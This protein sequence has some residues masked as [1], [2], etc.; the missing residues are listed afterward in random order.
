[1]KRRLFASLAAAA[2]IAAVCAPS[3]SIA[4]GRLTPEFEESAFAS[5]FDVYSETAGGTP[6]FTTDGFLMTDGLSENKILL[7]VPAELSTFAVE[8]DFYPIDDDLC[9]FS[10]GFYIYASNA[11]GT[12]DGIT[13]YNV[14]IERDYGSSRAALRV[15]RFD[16]GY[17]GVV[18]ETSIELKR[19]PV[20]MTVAAD[21]GR[22]KV[23]VYDDPVAAI[24]TVLPSYTPG[25][26]GLRTFR[27][28]AGKIGNFRVT[29][30]VIDP[31][32]SALTELIKKAESLAREDY[33][34]SSYAALRAALDAA[35]AAKTAGQSDVDEAASA[36]RA[37]LDSLV[38]KY[39]YSGLAELIAKADAELA[40]TGVYTTNTINSLAFVTARAK[41]TDETASED[42]VSEMYVALD[43]ALSDLTVYLKKIKN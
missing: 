19:L 30:D 27:G 23:Y 12:L 1:M 3:A 38:G 43:N 8:A 33:T 2:A 39:T 36:L 9:Q 22:V 29:A 17:K 7:K 25:R 40:K 15:H 41:Q 21:N 42:V 35:E 13:A 5:M 26:V 14:A 31:D 37:A 32:R 20:N 11:S 4:E 34:A 18:T 24:D 6:V 10:S 16:R 28:N